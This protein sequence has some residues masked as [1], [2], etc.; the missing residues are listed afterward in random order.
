MDKPGVAT[1]V[2]GVVLVYV[3]KS[4]CLSDRCRCG[5]G[6]TIRFGVSCGD[7]GGNMCGVGVEIRA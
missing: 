5:S 2:L 6:V 1:G 4:V 7:E 3:G